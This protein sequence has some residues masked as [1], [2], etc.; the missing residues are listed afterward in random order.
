MNVVALFLALA[1][2]EATYFLALTS[3]LIFGQLDILLFL[4]FSAIGFMF[5]ALTYVLYRVLKLQVLI[6]KTR[7]K[8][9]SERVA[10]RNVLR[11]PRKR[12]VVFQVVSEKPVKK[13]DVEK[14]FHETFKE[15]FG[16][17]GEGESNPKLVFYDE[18]SM[19]GIVRFVHIQK[20]KVF[21]TFAMVS[22]VS[23]GK[24]GFIPLKTTGTLR[25]AKEIV[26]TLSLD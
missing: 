12:Y 22:E 3:L 21:F 25:R 8:L 4:V 5:F 17:L 14:V 16:I 19:R 23:K 6:L 7:I 2:L 26:K 18:V 13:E 9:S 1:I 24:L 15:L 10:V 11:K 20:S